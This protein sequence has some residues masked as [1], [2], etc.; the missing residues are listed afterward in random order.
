MAMAPLK[1][2]MSGSTDTLSERDT[3]FRIQGVAYI[4]C[5]TA[6]CGRSV[7]PRLSG[8]VGAYTIDFSY[9]EMPLRLRGSRH[10]IIF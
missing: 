4:Y 2:P 7:S 10:I 8:L 1:V 9:F 3:T 6:G 5:F